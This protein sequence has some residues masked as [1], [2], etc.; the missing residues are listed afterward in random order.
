MFRTIELVRPTLL[1]DEA[2]TFMRDN[3]EIRGIINSGHLKGGQ[4]IRLVGDDHEPRVF[5]TWAPV[6][7][8]AIGHLPDTIEDRSIIVPMVRRKKEEKTPRMT[9]KVEAALQYANRFLARWAADNKE[10]LVDADPLIPEAL[11]DRAM[12]N[13]RPLLAIADAVGGTWP[14]RARNAA[15]LLRRHE[16]I[17][18]SILPQVLEKNN[19][20]TF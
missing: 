4:V 8:A 13:W 11:N 18:E 17:S 6:A 1:I 10:R 14:E 16:G 5:S 20:E 2:D 12:D 9:R 19:V 3:E 15:L 7:L